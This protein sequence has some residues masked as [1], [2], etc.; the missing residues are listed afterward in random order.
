MAE[1]HGELVGVR[2]PELQRDRLLRVGLRH[3]L[4]VLDRHL[5]DPPVEVQR[6]GLHLLEGRRKSVLRSRGQCNPGFM[7]TVEGGRTVVDTGAVC[8]GT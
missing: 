8:G 4:E 7:K 3:Q 1:V 6:E 5:G 2:T